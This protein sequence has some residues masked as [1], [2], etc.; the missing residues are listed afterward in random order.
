MSSVYARPPDLDRQDSQPQDVSATRA[1]MLDA[2]SAGYDSG[3]RPDSTE[4]R[5]PQV[6]RGRRV[7]IGYLFSALIVLA[8]L[9]LWQAAIWIWHLEAYIL[10]SPWQV[11]QAFGQQDTRD[12]IAN[13]VG[14]TVVEALTGFGVCVVVGVVLAVA[15]FASRIVR[16]ALYPLLV[17]SQAIPT[18]AIGAVLVIALGYGI[19]PKIVVVTLYAFFAVTVSV[20]DSL[21]SLDPEL[22]ALL[23]TLGAS[24]LQVLWTARLPA[25]LPGFFT[26]A[27]LAVTYSIAGAI[28]G[29]WVGSTGGLGYA[30]Q[31]AANQ[32]ASAEVLAIVVVMAALGLAA[33]VIVAALERLLVPWSRGL[34]VR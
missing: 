11:A 13:N 27:K 5:A 26:G 8:F 16:D 1:T 17:A 18:I 22:P 9:L 21:R 33:F 30:L 32:L 7:P 3:R 10:P 34:A 2:L 25:A 20:Y 19:A 4:Q 23:R 12:L 14:V 24:P 15:M 6:R 31:M 28:Y 29:E